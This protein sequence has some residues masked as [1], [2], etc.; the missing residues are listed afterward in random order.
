M[1]ED[2]L[3]EH[4]ER[5]SPAEQRVAAFFRDK[6]EDV[7]IS[8][9]TALASRTGTS[10]AT[11]VRTAKALGFAGLADLKRVLAG[12]MRQR[13]TLA[14]RMKRTLEEAGDDPASAFTLAMSIHEQSLASLRRSIAPADFRAAVEMIGASRRVVVFGLGPSSAI[15]QY[16]VLQLSR[17]GLDALALVNSGLLFADDVGKL[18][19]G[20]LVIAF[21]YSRVYRELAV[22]LDACG[23][24]KVPVLLVTDT[25]GPRLKSQVRLVLTAAR[26]RA[27]MLSMHM[28]T[29]ALVEAMLVGVAAE[30]RDQTIDSL[31]ALNEARQKL[32][33][34]PMD[35][36]LDSSQFR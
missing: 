14:D 20:D 30:R 19:P 23:E 11:V 18:R 10:D 34:E 8:S 3:T 22:L 27:E 5:L 7:L 28:A 36:H 24:V 17:M 6:S 21:A 35:L 12:E 2:N 13:L 29:L 33:G 1:F 9:A 31:R 4:F 25:L 32:A 16:F 15:A 26:G